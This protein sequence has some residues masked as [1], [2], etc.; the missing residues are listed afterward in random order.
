MY[1]RAQNN[2]NMQK[3]DERIKAKSNLVIGPNNDPREQGQGRKQLVGSVVQEPVAEGGNGKTL[4]PGELE[5]LQRGGG[6]VEM[7]FHLKRAAK[8]RALGDES[9][10]GCHRIKVG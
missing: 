6:C 1:K 3:T 8:R 2:G 9:G 5:R 7:A 4:F 10:K